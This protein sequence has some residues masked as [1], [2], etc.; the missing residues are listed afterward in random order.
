MD[1]PTPDAPVPL[2][3]GLLAAAV[4][5]REGRLRGINTRF[6][7]LLQLPAGEVADC[8]LFG[9]F[10]ESVRDEVRATAQR[11]LAGVP[12]HVTWP[13]AVRGQ[14][15]AQHFEW[16]LFPR[17]LHDGIAGL[18]VSVV[19]LEHQRSEWRRLALTQDRFRNI[20]AG[21][22]AMV[23]VS[24]PDGAVRNTNRA[25][26]DFIGGDYPSPDLW[27]LV[28]H[29]DDLARTLEA[30]SGA[31]ADGPPR[32]VNYRL[33]RHDG[34]WRWIEERVIR[35]DAD[36]EE[37]WI[38]SCND[39][40]EQ[41]EL[42][43]R[44]EQSIAQTEGILATA[45]DAIITV[46]EDNRIVGFNPAAEQM[47]GRSAAEMRSQ[48]A[49]VLVPARLRR[50]GAEPGLFDA[51][52][53]ARRLGGPGICGLRPDGSEFPVEASVSR[54]DTRAGRRVTAIVRDM[55]SQM[56]SLQAL[57]DR[58]ERLQ[59]AMD[60]AS[61]GG[62]EIEI[63]TGRLIASRGA[64][65]LLGLGDEPSRWI[66]SDFTAPVH[67][68]DRA[69]VQA[70][71]QSIVTQDR[72]HD[73]EFRAVRP[74]GVRWLFGRARLYRDAQG[75][76]RR[77]VGV[78]MDIHERKVAE[79]QLRLLSQRL[80]AVQEEERRHIARELHDQIGQSLT[81]AM[82]NFQMLPIDR[83]S[84]PAIEVQ[85]ALAGVLSQVREL[86]LNLRPSMLDSLGLEPALRW[87]LDRQAV[88]GKFEVQLDC[89]ETGERLP[90]AT[91]TVVFRLVQEALTNVLRHA[92]ARQVRVQ[93]ERAGAVA[94][95]RV[96]DDG[97]G[98]DT[99]AT[100]SRAIDGGSFG[101]VGM[102]ERAEL[103][104]G[105]LRFESRPGAGT[106][107]IAELPLAG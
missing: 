70:V 57:Q 26:R 91:E 2:P 97:V 62:V 102:R 67:P 9:L 21:L 17:T 60:T 31:A 79:E 76:P 13:V 20:A 35:Q 3:D 93:V 12:H 69:R 5:D 49:D 54:L 98:F 83:A 11:A 16:H 28:I 101:V 42:R 10:E 64:A 32:I 86:S 41:R 44:L 46:D 65:Q 14:R 89:L 45:L 100:L 74:D 34:A 55:T 78:L 52:A 8:T 19:P 59:L 95:L 105:T 106:V 99:E 107:V 71:I 22:A 104:G 53:G 103:A 24:G 80:L 37:L 27:R 30:R 58:K 63:N 82:I 23:W 33:R 18:V 51:T 29:P 77:V 68:D 66:L 94:R 81:A 87:Y 50:G 4:T 47:F 40:T 75:R 84:G 88:L 56:R 48:D 43:E 92:R 6:A 39:V 61:L 38:A 15:V 1:M 73:A 25:W 85:Q 90:P 36:G 7:D 72:P 96:S